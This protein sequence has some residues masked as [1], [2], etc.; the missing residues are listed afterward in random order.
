MSDK[1]DPPPPA[2]PNPDTPPSEAG[3]IGG[4]L[5]PA[6]TGLFNPRYREVTV[7][8]IIF[9]LI[10]GAIMNAAIKKKSA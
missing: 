10:V 4:A 1:P 9:G 6:S 8:S 3:R 5:P 7:A 2:T